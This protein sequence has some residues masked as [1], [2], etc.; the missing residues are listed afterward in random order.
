MHILGECMRLICVLAAGSS[1]ATYYSVL[2]WTYGVR[3]LCMQAFTLAL[4]WTLA[5]AWAW[6]WASWAWS[7][8]SALL[9]SLTSVR[10]WAIAPVRLVVVPS[11]GAPSA[12]L[13][14]QVRGPAYLPSRL[15][16]G[17]VSE[18]VVL[19]SRRAAP[20]SPTRTRLIRRTISPLLFH[21]SAAADASAFPAP[22]DAATPYTDGQT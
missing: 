14:M 3:V 1:L 20:S 10:I 13:G 11:Q 12:R 7:F 2:R 8:C 17:I 16:A 5:W 19:Y 6:A 18:G 15:L 22:P 21:R 4:A 9:V